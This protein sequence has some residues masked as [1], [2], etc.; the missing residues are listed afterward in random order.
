MGDKSD[1]IPGVPGI[2]E[3]TAMGLI[4][5]Y[6]DLDGVYKNLDKIKGKLQEKLRDN[7]ELARLSYKLATIDTNVPLDVNIDE[8]RLIDPFNQNSRKVMER[9]NF[10]SVLQ[11]LEFTDGGGETVSN[12]DL[13]GKDC[14]SVEV[15]N[16]AELKKTLSV[17]DGE[18]A[19]YVGNTIEFAF[20]GKRNY[21]IKLAEGFLDDG[22]NYGE[23]L[24]EIAKVLENRSVK[25][26]IYDVKS[27]MQT[28]NRE[29]R[30]VAV[31]NADDILIKAYLVDSNINY[32]DIYE[33]LSAY[34]ISD[35]EIA[36]SMFG[37]DKKISLQMSESLYELYKNIEL[38]LAYLLYDMEISGFAVDRDMLESLREDFRRR[39]TEL[40][41][42][43]KSIAGKDFNVN[44]P[45]QLG[46][47]L[48]VDL[49]LKGGKKTKSGYSTN[50][51]TLSILSFPLF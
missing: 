20:D 11:R 37:L 10:K 13:D 39:V 46:E 14:E 49:G 47:V 5:E 28:M 29:S 2:G 50:I 16:I 45:K 15:D 21:R 42:A 26:Y 27:L 4:A 19:V 41:D 3:K 34:S 9:L 23:A 8:C 44:S 40:S 1:N 48:F 12:D 43:I 17:K 25:K 6:G 51:E 38:P 35:K 32:R 30:P 24:L 18:I 36:S 31:E 33:L 7:E 22:I